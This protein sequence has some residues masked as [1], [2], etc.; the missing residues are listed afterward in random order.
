[1]DLVTSL[2]E[3][4]LLLKIAEGN[5]KAFIQLFELYG[6][7]LYPFLYR[8]VK[9]KPIAEELIQETML[10]V[11][12]NRDRLSSI[13]HPRKWIFRI[14]SNLA[15]T[16]LKRHLLEKRIIDELKDRELGYEDPEQEHTL[17][18]LKRHVKE[19]VRLLPPE[20]QRIYL[21]S[22]EAGMSREEIA[23]QLNITPKTVK[24]TI[25]AALKDIR[26]HLEKAGY[27]LPLFCIP[28]I[29]M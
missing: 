18:E 22:R 3:K 12:L 13:D 14:A 8:T 1:L 26:A 24:N 2:D 28:F 15:Y 17:L 9:S 10:K 23:I 20:R 4:E 11:W 5:E 25:Y 27:I 29:K 19:A 6:K 16:G 7:L 21:L